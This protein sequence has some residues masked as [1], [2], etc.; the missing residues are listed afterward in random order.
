MHIDS[1]VVTGY[2]MLPMPWDDMQEFVHWAMLFSLRHRNC[3]EDGCNLHRPFCIIRHMKVSTQS[4]Q[5]TSA[6]K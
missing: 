6:R 1:T 3:E 5:V 2:S 4:H